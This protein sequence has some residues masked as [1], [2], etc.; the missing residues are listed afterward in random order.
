M[1]DY[2]S[3][4]PS[5][6]IEFEPNKLPEGAATLKIIAENCYGKQSA[7]IEYNF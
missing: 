3:A 4:N 2:Y 6:V 7:P 5:E 1:N